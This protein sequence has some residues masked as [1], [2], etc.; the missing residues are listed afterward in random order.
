MRWQELHVLVP[1][2]IAAPLGKALMGLG[3]LGVQEDLPPGQKPKFRQPWDTGPAPRPPRTVLLKAWFEQR[4]PTATLDALLDGREPSWRE[5]AEEDWAESWK[6]HFQPVRLSD[7]LVIAPPWDAPD[8]ALI[9]E[10]GMAF[11]TGNHPT[12]LAC[13]RAVDRYARPGQTLL[14][15]GCGTGILALAGAKLGMTALGVDIDPDAV[16]EADRHAAHNRLSDRVRFATTPIAA[17]NGPFDLVV[18]NLFAEVLAGMAPE[19]LRCSAGPIALAGIL[20]ERADPVRAAFQ[21]RPVLD[22]QTEEGWVS[23]VF[24]GP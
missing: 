16:A 13:L 9:L 21:S 18:A 19:L 24:G 10:P 12:T 15:V 14:D 20:A 2:R 7:R 17:V 5:C 22:D 4:P 6:A 8:G 1:R 23:L 3:A 11:G